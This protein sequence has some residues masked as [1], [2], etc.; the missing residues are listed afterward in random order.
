MTF[1]LSLKIKI[2]LYLICFKLAFY[3]SYGYLFII[4]FNQIKK[5]S[6]QLQD[7]LLNTLGYDL[8][9]VHSTLS[10]RPSGAG[11]RY[12]KTANINQA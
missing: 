6:Y 10:R 9:A 8:C 4:N 2:I 7:V 1:N 5:V 12:I 3:L 11:C